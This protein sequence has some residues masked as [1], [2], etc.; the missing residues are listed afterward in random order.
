MDLSTIVVPTD[1]SDH[2]DHALRYAASLGERF[3]ATLH[4]L[5]ALTLHEYQ[6][7][8][9]ESSFPDLGPWLE[10]ADKVARARLDAGALHHGGEAEATVVKKVVRGVDASHA[11]LDYA[12]DVSAELIVMATRGHSVLSHLLMGSTTERVLRFTKCPVL[13]VEKG[14][15]DFVDPLTLVVSLHRVVVADDLSDT[16]LRAL[17][18]AV[19]FLGPYAPEV[20]LVHVVD[21]DVPAFYA[22]AGIDS[23]L[24][25]NPELR[26]RIEARLSKRLDEALPQGWARQ[27]EVVEGKPHK[28][29]RAYALEVEAD[30]VVVGAE[31]H[32]D[33]SER[34]AGGTTERITRLA[35]CPVLVA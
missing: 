12:Q 32:I 29:L 34:V 5:H 28:A 10:Q 13:V 19:D 23:M 30:L 1:F 21:D 6:G 16:A 35:P 3:G 8:K 27:A 31:T 26:P 25:L 33:L 20:H 2:A 9:D 11:I 7:P 4:L 14:E 22:M 17:M 24:Q 18:W 15:P